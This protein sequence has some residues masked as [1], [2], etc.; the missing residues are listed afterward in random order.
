MNMRLV[1]GGV[2]EMM[3]MMMMMMMMMMALADAYIFCIQ[4]LQISA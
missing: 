3:I 2:L 1:E 4:G